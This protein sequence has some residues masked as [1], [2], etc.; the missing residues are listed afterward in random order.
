[1]TVLSATAWASNAE[2]IAA[3]HTLGYVTSSDAVLDVTYGRGVWWQAFRPHYLVTND[4]DPRCNTEFSYDFRYLPIGWMGKFDVIAF[5]PPYVSPGGRATTTITDFHAA[6]GTKVVAATPARLHGTLIAPGLQNCARILK[7][8]GRI[9]QKTQNYVSSGTLQPGTYWAYET[10]TRLGLTLIDELCYLRS[11]GPQPT[12]NL[13]GTPRRQ[14][15]SRRNYSTLLV[16][17]KTKDQRP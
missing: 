15:H 9:L 6:Y 14:V 7:P 16:W 4:T 2:L 12:E 1:M 11:P 17:K 10:G 3:C 13:D 8:G 5:D